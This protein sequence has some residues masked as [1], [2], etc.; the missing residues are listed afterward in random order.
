[1]TLSQGVVVLWL[2]F[3]ALACGLRTWK[4]WTRAPEVK[5][6]RLLV[7]CVVLSF[8]IRL[9]GIDWELSG[10]Y[11]QDEGIYYAAAQAINEGDLYPESFIYGHLTYYAAALVLWVQDLFANSLLRLAGLF[12]DVSDQTGLSWV[13][14]RGL[15]AICSA[16]TVVPVFQIARRFGG[17]VAAGIAAGLVVFSSLYNEVSHLIISDVPAAFFATLCLLFVSRL[18][19]RERLSDYLW[20]GC[21]AGL[22]AGCKYPAGVVAIAIPAVWIYWRIKTRSWSWSLL[23]AGLTS[24]LT[25]LATM[26]ALWSRTDSAFAGAGKDFFFGL[27]QYSKGGWIG[28]TPTSNTVWYG[29]KMS[30]NFGLP[31]LIVGGLGLLVLQQRTRRQVLLILPFPAIYLGLITSMNM[32]VKRNLQPALPIVAAILALGIVAWIDRFGPSRLQARGVL[33]TLLVVVVLAIPVGRT[34]AQDLSMV[35]PSTRELAVDWINRNVPRGAAFVQEEYTPKLDYKKYQRMKRR[36]AARYTLEEI[37]D[38]TWDYLLLAGPAFYR[39][40]DPANWTEPHHEEFARR[41]RKMFEFELVRDFAPG[42]TRFGPQILLYKIDP[43]PLEYKTEHLFELRGEGFR[44]PRSDAYLLL[45]GYLAAGEYSA[46]VVASPSEVDGKLV[47][48]SR[49]NQHRVEADLLGSR[50]TFSVPR[51]DKYF[52]YTYL[53]K[54]SVISGLWIGPSGRA[55]PADSG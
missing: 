37:T 42:K 50:G 28:V 9:L 27:R 38:P 46:A 25:F 45:K 21:A 31:A 13:L 12:F 11:Y 7:I 23:Q 20:A 17:L 52:F 40:L 22:A 16:L 36:F 3:L 29:E 2:S 14:L 6:G 49:S 39:F 19:D 53:A 18:I 35:R 5:A 4:L 51:N 34:V 41:Y 15:S 10:R 47:V 55:G 54:D 30:E 26:P 32:V 48:L 1:M 44:Y 43:D 24:V 8:V 33:V